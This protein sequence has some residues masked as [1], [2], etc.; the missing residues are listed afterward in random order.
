MGNDVNKIEPQDQ[1]L[2][3][4]RTN[5]NNT[6]DQATHSKQTTQVIKDQQENERITGDI[7]YPFSLEHPTPKSIYT[8]LE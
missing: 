4:D 1:T 8:Q 3:A 5:N 2:H 6:E 7:F